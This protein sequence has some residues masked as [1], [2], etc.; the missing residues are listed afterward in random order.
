MLLCIFFRGWGV[1]H[2]NAASKILGYPHSATPLVENLVLSIVHEPF[3]VCTV[4]PQLKSVF[5]LCS[6]AGVKN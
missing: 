5:P 1:C 3:L 6:E 2:H 4:G